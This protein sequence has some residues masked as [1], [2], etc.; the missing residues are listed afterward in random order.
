MA[1]GT[2]PSA[3]E[4]IQ[5]LFGNSYHWDLHISCDTSAAER[6]L[7]SNSSTSSLIASPLVMDGW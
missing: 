6:G 3:D 2:T 7:I 5:L 4:S 1:A